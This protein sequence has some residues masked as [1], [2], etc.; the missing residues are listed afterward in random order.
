MTIT[1]HIDDNV[2]YMVSSLQRLIRQPSV[3]A[4]GR[5][6]SRC[7]SLVRIMLAKSGIRSRLLYLGDGTA[8]IVYGHIKSRSNPDR[9]LMFYN[10]YDV[11]P[12][13]PLDMWTREPFGGQREGNYIY[14]RGA[15]DDK[16]ELIARI[17][18][19]EATLRVTGDVPCNIKFFIEGQEEIGSPHVDR[20][21][22]KYRK[23]LG[24]D[25]IIWEFGYVNADDT[26]I[27]GLGMKGLLYVELVLQGPSR[28]LHSSLAAIVPNPA[29][30][31]VEALKTLRAP[32]GRIL[33]A[34]WYD[35][36]VPLTAR[37]KE[38]IRREPFASGSFKREFGITRYVGN[39]DSTRAKRELAT[40]ATCNIAG[41]H[42]GYGG[43]GAKTV[44]PGTATAK[45]DFRLVP[46][47]NPSR[48]VARLRRHLK[49]HGFHDIR[50]RVY[51]GLQ[52]ARTDPD[53]P[54]V[55]HVRDAAD[56]VF[57]RSVINVSN[58]G[59]GPMHPFASILGAP[60]VS[61]GCTH[62]YARIHSP[63]EFARIDLLQKA[64]K[65]MALIME[66][67]GRAGT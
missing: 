66:N 28:D 17:K 16:G 44:L 35:D 19:V 6:I 11:Q 54:L 57:G 42:A 18:A 25:G 63:D 7:A 41:I 3:S 12:A 22:N 53:S 8:P 5:G 60:C 56:R 64:A 33:I 65:S 49:L 39:M 55:G 58:A 2:E 21:L 10:H 61:F 14:G 32:D 24:C 46:R 30:R 23:L 13:E 1:Q 48:Q 37:E 31:L 59:T 45:I 26:P 9:T 62:I 29:W 51:D 34:G 15:S 27:I 47:M 50:V 40:G 67:F 20:Y 4:T 43:P 52:A 36:V 38:L